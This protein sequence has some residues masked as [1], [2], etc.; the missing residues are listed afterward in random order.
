M[1]QFQPR[2]HIR[3]N[4]RLPVV[5]TWLLCIHWQEQ[6]ISW[7]RLPVPLSARC[8]HAR[9]R[10]ARL[11]SSGECI[12]SGHE[13]CISSHVCAAVLSARVS[14]EGKGAGGHSQLQP[15]PERAEI[16]VSIT[17]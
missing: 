16:T 1:I 15:C 5:E 10:Y 8:Q 3:A 13:D 7:A 11:G 9:D 4:S 2:H 12:G 14:I 17:A 6:P